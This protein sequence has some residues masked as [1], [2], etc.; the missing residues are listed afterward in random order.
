[1][2]VSLFAHYKLPED[3]QAFDAHYFSTHLPLAQAMPGLIEARLHR[4]TGA[5][6]GQP[7]LYFI[8]ELVFPDGA[9]LKAAMASP[10]GMAAAKDLMKFA[11]PLVKMYIA[12]TATS[13]V[14]A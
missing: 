11:G 13:P 7:D 6:M 10:E 9:A 12:Q 8:C 2:T 1:M 5:P 4:I 3:M 14:T